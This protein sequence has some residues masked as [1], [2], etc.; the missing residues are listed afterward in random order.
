M[1]IYEENLAFNLNLVSKLAP[2]HRGGGGVGRGA[3]KAWGSPGDDKEPRDKAARVR[4]ALKVCLE[5]D[6]AEAAA[7]RC[8]LEPSLKAPPG[9]KGSKP[10]N[11]DKLAFNLNLT[12]VS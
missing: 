12:M 8:K 11:E 5:A 10:I 3:V 6:V 4:A 7:G 2:L 9:V 1:P